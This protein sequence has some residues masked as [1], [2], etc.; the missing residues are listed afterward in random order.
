MS[1]IRLLTVQTAG[2][3]NQFSEKN[4]L[5]KLKQAVT[6]KVVSI[7]SK[8]NSLREFRRQILIWNKSNLKQNNQLIRKT[9]NVIFYCNCHADKIKLKLCWL[10]LHVGFVFVFGHTWWDELREKL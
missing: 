1:C 8:F 9:Q 10:L 3:Q 4:Y 2:R 7:I 6:V 5:A